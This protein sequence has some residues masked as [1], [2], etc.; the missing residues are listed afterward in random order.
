MP[1]MQTRRRFLTGVSLAG[2]A[3]LLG[4]QRAWAAEG[5][6]E[7]TTVRIAKAG[8]ICMA[9]QYVADE[10]LRAEGFTDIRY[11]EVPPGS[12][13]VKGPLAR[14]EVDFASE[15]AA[16][17]IIAI[18]GGIPLAVLAGVH[19]GCFVLFGNEAIRN[20][21]D[22]AGKNVGIDGLGS[23]SHV[24]VAA[25]AAYVG[26]DPVKDIHWVT[27]GW[28]KQVELFQSGGI[29]AFLIFPSPETQFLRTQGI[30]H[31]VVNSTVDR[32]W[33][34][35]FCCMLNGNPEY[36]RNFPVATKRVIRAI[37]KAADLCVTDPT[38]V[39][40][41]LV[42]GGFTPAY[43]YALQT[44]S[45]L[46]YDKWRE[47]DPEDTM[48]FYAL[49]L[50]DAGMIKSSPTKIIAASA[51]WRFLNEVKREMKV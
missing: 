32:P 8:A 28:A 36:V 35:Y 44:I 26:V 25:M 19:V 41:R 51:D 37:L 34:D 9:P 15:F 1:P 40:R 33:S 42:D 18:D 12:T 13:G 17:V 39:A 14:R 5:A 22:L 38:G 48:R 24:F 30:G 49:R 47:Y 6:L 23:P 45:E 7:T 4:S 27:T 21:T 2:A 43:D 20:I 11:V 16:P 10:L 3:G 50:H 31:V 29:D 46:P